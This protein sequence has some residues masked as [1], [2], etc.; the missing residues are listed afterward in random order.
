MKI[1]GATFKEI[2]NKLWITEQTAA[3]KF[4]RIEN[5]IA[6]ALKEKWHYKYNFFT[7]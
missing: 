1:E 7:K 3:K 4:Y 6:Q 5:R 2:W